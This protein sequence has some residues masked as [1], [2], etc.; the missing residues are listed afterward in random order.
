MTAFT[1]GVAL[2]LTY[3]NGVRYI[4]F[5]LLLE[6]LLMASVI[7]VNPLVVYALIFP[8]YKKEYVDAAFFRGYL[9]S[10]IAYVGYLGVMWLIIWIPSSMYTA[11]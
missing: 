8:K 3:L 2:F 9:G 4:K 1:L 5:N 10:V 6:R 7:L 11:W